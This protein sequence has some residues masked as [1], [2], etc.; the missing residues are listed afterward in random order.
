MS[1][2]SHDQNDASNDGIARFIERG[3]APFSWHR[4]ASIYGLLHDRAIVAAV[5]RL[6]RAPYHEAESCKT[7]Q[8]FV[9][10]P[11]TI[12]ALENSGR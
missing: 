7:G 11:F 9:L 5:G 1:G 3:K 2:L 8:T 4:F 6:R 12:D 10:F